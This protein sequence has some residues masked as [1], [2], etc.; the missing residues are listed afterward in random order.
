MTLAG[1][2]RGAALGAPALVAL[3]LHLPSLGNGFVRDD[4]PLI[5]ENPLLRTPGGLATLLGGDFLAATGFTSGLWRPLPLLVFWIEGR[6]GGWTPLLFHA[7]NVGLYTATTLV[8][9]L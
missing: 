1:L 5:V 9:S 2:R 7:A 8:L 6:L 3:L 4:V